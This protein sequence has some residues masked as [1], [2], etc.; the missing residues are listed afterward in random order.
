MGSGFCALSICVL[1][2]HKQYRWSTTSRDR[3]N[4][5]QAQHLRTRIDGRINSTRSEHR[6]GLNDSGSGSTG[7]RFERGEGGGVT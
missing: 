4:M 2:I 3:Y 1:R 5:A 6:D 7:N